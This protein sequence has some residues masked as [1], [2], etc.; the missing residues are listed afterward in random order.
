MPHG[1][2]EANLE[3]ARALLVK[4]R[5]RGVVLALLPEYFFADLSG[6][7]RSDEGVVRR[8]LA[9]ETRDGEMAIA[10]HTI[11]PMGEGLANVGL[12][13]AGGE[14]VLEQPKVHP[15]RREVESGIVAGD[16]FQAAP[17]GRLTVG[18]LVCS[19]VLYPEA[20]R[21]LSLQGATLLLN[22]VMSPHMQVDPWREAREALYVARAYDSGAF[23]L[24]AG[25]YHR[26][27]PEI[28]GRSL[29]ASPWGML[30]HYRDAFSTEL[31]VADLDLVQL[32]AHRQR[33]ASFPARRPE[34]YRALVEEEGRP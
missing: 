24:K 21:I 13:Y 18:M 15:M 29:V 8:F 23:L 9:E 17:V 26:G 34:A 19:D 28:A 7:P 27:A 25:G 20:A 14:A 2:L 31:L 4:A 3:Q 11:E 33:Q 10:A 6:D 12:V 32:E 30:A 5:E 1:D 22:P 16:L